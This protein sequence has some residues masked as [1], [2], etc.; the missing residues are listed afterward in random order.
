M[1]EKIS[2][3]IPVYNTKEYLEDC[4]NSVLEQTWPDFELILIDDGSQDGSREICEELCRKDNRIRSIFQEHK[5]VSAAR[6]AGIEAAEGK[7]LFFLDSDD[8]IHPQLLEAL[9]KVQGENHTILAM[10]GLYYRGERIFQ[11]PLNWKIENS[12]TWKGEYLDNHRAVRACSFHYTK[13]KLGGIGGKMILRKAV[14]ELRFDEKLSRGEDIWFLYQLV[15][16][17]ADVAVL[18][19]D[20]YYYNNSGKKEYSVEIC[21]SLYKYQ[22]AVCEYEMKHNK[23]VEAIH[24]EWCLL[25][26]MVVW[27]EMGKRN[28]DTRLKEYVKNLIVA[29]KEEELFSKVDRCRKLIFYLGCICYPLYKL[30]ANF[31]YWYHITLGV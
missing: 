21:K 1:K 26:E 19:R 6:N 9:R 25:C 20:W 18:P 8:M 14:K 10:T 17:G 13:A 31:A 11:K 27:R 24:M 28:Q 30:I 5:G 7:Y 29:E 2:V 4:V 15:F 12:H 3:I 23:T 22:K 16:S